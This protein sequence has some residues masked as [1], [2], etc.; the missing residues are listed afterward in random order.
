MKPLAVG[1]VAAAF[2]KLVVDPLGVHLGDHGREPI[3]FVI[4]V[5]GAILYAILAGVAVT[6]VFDQYKEV[7]KAVVGNDK[8][9]FLIYRDEQLPLT[10]H[11]L[12]GASSLVLLAAVLLLDYQGDDVA[13]ILTTFTVAFIF[14]LVWAVT[15]ELDDFHRS[16]WFRVNIPEEWYQIDVKLHFYGPPEQSDQCRRS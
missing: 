10:M 14:A 9:T 16:I 15:T 6:S 8:D 1:A 4:V 13:G 7:S 5:L 12:M 11:V 2:W 3:M